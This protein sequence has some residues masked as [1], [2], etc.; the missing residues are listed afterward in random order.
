VSRRRLHETVG[1]P[2]R[3]RQIELGIV[4]GFFLGFLSCSCLCAGLLAKNFALQRQLVILRR[5]AAQR[6][7]I[8]TMDRALLGWLCHLWP[9]VLGA[10]AIVRPETVLRWHR[11]GFR[12]WWRW[13]CRNEGGRPW[14]ARELRE[15]I[16]RMSREN[17]FWGAPRIHGELLKL[18]VE[19]AESTVAKY[20]VRLPVAAVRAGRPSCATMQVKLPPSTC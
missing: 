13:K 19:A 5:S 15:L 11:A 3:Y 4:S 14:I 12:A 20:M 2:C 6:L 16:A 7:R 10:I 8:T 1:K 18:G 9:D 17:P